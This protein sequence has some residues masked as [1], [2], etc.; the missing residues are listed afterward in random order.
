MG[1]RRGWFTRAAPMTAPFA[2]VHAASFVSALSRCRSGVVL[3]DM[4]LFP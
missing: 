2:A 1:N 4:L 3:L